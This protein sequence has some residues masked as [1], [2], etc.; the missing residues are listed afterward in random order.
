MDAGGPRESKNASKNNTNHFQKLKNLKRH[1]KIGKA[2]FP[3][4]PN[5]RSNAPAAHIKGPTDRQELS[6][7]D[8]SFPGA[9]GGEVRDLDLAEAQKSQ[10]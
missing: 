1:T 6:R 9:P 7:V 8:K 10:S 3:I 4:H 5:S 2:I